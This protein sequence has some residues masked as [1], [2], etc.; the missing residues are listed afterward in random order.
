MAAP[1][2]SPQAAANPALSSHFGRVSADVSEGGVNTRPGNDSAGHG[3]RQ[4]NNSQESIVSNLSFMSKPPGLFPSSSNVSTA[5]VQT[6]DTDLTSASQEQPNSLAQK[7]I[8]AQ[9][10]RPH[11]PGLTNGCKDGSSEHVS[12]ASTSPMSL[13]T[14]YTT[15]GT[16]R[17]ASGAIKSAI[18]APIHDSIS[19]SVNKSPKELAQVC[20][21]PI[22]SCLP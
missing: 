2:D 22:F 15:K 18:S 3:D 4:L 13:D 12:S 11:T 14:P 7:A 8:D 20:N 16:K 19:S 5:T 21:L 6:V 10:Q 17:T 1:H 9:L